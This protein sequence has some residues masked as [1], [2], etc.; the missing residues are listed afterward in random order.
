M[1]QPSAH[2]NLTGTVTSSLKRNSKLQGHS[3][4]LTQILGSTGYDAAVR[5]DEGGATI[6]AAVPS[7]SLVYI[8]DKVEVQVAGPVNTHGEIR[9][10]ELTRALIVKRIT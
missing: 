5:L 10:V 2:T 4:H 7:G 8:G 6:R 1:T 3:P 9:V